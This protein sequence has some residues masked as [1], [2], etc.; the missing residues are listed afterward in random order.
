MVD[1]REESCRVYE[2]HFSP[3]LRYSATGLAFVLQSFSAFVFFFCHCTCVCAHIPI[4]VC[5][6]VSA[7]CV[8][9]LLQGAH[10]VLHHPHRPGAG[11]GDAKESDGQGQQEGPRATLLPMTGPH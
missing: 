7:V 8:C 10:G 9:V 6:M 3:Y 11:G 2:G 4:H 1:I 5:T